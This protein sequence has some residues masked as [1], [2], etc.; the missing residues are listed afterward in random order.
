MVFFL[1]F[2]VVRKEQKKTKSNDS[3][4]LLSLYD[5][6]KLRHAATSTQSAL[7]R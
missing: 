7:K 4:F 6:F 3:C 1:F 5:F 2:L